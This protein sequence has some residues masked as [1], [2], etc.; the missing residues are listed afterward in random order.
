MKNIELFL[1]YFLKILLMLDEL[2]KTN[3][4]MKRWWFFKALS[5]IRPSEKILKKG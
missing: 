5:F 4:M 2:F 1:I 3:N